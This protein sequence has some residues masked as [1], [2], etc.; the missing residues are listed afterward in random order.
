[1]K[2]LLLAVAAVMPLFA[3]GCHSCN[4][5]LDATFCQ[6]CNKGQMVGGCWKGQCGYGD[7]GCSSCVRGQ[8]EEIGEGEVVYEGY[9]GQEMASDD[10]GCESC[11][12]RRHKKRGHGRGLLGH[13]LPGH[14]GMH[15][16]RAG[17]P[18][19]AGPPTAQVA[20]PYYTTRA[21]R[22]FLNPNPRSIGR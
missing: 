18:M 20:Y 15:P 14:G 19:A 13:G 7:S 4:R 22:D 6:P 3:T 5:W 1:M 16:R 17:P 11:R 10:C 21:P 9:D 8:G 12:G 2:R